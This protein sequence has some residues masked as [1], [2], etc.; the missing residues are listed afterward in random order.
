MKKG[1]PEGAIVYAIDKLRC[2]KL[3][4]KYE[5]PF[6]I[7]RRTRGGSYIVNDNTGTQ[8]SRCSAPQQ[9]KLVVENKEKAVVEIA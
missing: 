8:M 6:T 7:V 3:D 5:G 9:L 1:F 2:S 4:P